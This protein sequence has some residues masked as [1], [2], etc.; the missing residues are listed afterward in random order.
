M[1]LTVINKEDKLY[2]KHLLSLG[3]LMPPALYCIGNVN[4]LTE[5][6]ASI[7]TPWRNNIKV[8]SSKKKINAVLKSFLNKYH[9]AISIYSEQDKYLL[10]VLADDFIPHNTI[11]VVMN[12]TLMEDL[13]HSDDITFELRIKYK[14]LDKLSWIADDDGLVICPIA[15]DANLDSDYYRKLN[16]YNSLVQFLCALGDV[17]V[18]PDCNDCVGTI[19]ED[20]THEA[21][22]HLIQALES[23]RQRNQRVII[24]KE[25][26]IK[27]YN[28]H[29]G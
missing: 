5:S 8:D 7:I 26:Y 6:I 21:N 23:A 16:T 9:P 14:E 4:L 18:I 28:S 20:K 19:L 12:P 1:E 27:L 10:D 22:E 29:I 24:N 25:A 11:A 3:E 13:L 2:P 15:P 17:V